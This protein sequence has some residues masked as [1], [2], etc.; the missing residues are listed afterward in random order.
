MPGEL[1]RYI[2][3][4]HSRFIIQQVENNYMHEPKYDLKRREKWTKYLRELKQARK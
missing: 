2:G 1:I 3:A 4:V